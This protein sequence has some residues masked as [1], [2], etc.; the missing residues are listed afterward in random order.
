M[1]QD[2]FGKFCF[3]VIFGHVFFILFGLMLLIFSF[4]A[5]IYSTFQFWPQGSACGVMHQ[6]DVI[7]E[8]TSSL[9]K[10]LKISACKKGLL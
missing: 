9:Q 4:L 2:M 3:M 5:F 8:Y 7:S 6:N 1:L 10:S